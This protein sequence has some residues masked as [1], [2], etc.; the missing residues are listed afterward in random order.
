[1]NQRKTSTRYYLFEDVLWE[2]PSFAQL[3]QR[4][5]IAQL[6][7]LAG[8]V[9]AREKGKGKCPLVRPKIRNDASYYCDG[10]IHLVPKHRS[11]GGLLHEMAHALGPRDR[12]TH[13]PAFRRR[14]FRL[15]KTYGDWN[16]EV[17]FK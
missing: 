12:L 1:M 7:L 10:V 6:Q 5:S 14:C 16:G 13:G 9:W 15:Y 4:R 8:L 17:D 3:R 2:V 11:V